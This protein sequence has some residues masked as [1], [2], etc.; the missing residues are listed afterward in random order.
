M[1][2]GRRLADERRRL[3]LN[4]EQMATHLN[5]GRST[6]A[7]LETDRSGLDAQRLVEFGERGVDVSYVL[8]G[9]PARQAAGRA[10]DWELVELILTGLWQWSTKHR[11]TLPPAK[12]ALALKILYEY[13]AE[14]GEVDA[15]RLDEV[16][17][18]AA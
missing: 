12:V 8:T 6:L 14:K 15:K 2:F 13:F 11:V 10:L 4:Q 16:M 9:L 1:S 5:V 3:G 17:Q 7:M 18:L